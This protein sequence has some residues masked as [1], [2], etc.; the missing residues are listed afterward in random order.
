MKPARFCYHDPQST[1]DAMALLAQYGGEARIVAGGQSLVPLMNFRLACPGHLVGI[2]KITSLDYIRRKDQTLCIGALTRQRAVERSELV[3]LCNPLLVEASHYI[4]RPAIR[5]RGTVCGSLAHAD[6]AAEWPALAALLDATLVVSGPRGAGWAFLE[7][8]R[9]YGDFALV[10]VATWITADEKAICTGGDIAL[11]SVGPVPVRA[12]AAEQR[13]RGEPLTENLFRHVAAGVQEE[14]APDSDLHASA[15]YRR[16]LTGVL[17]C[18]NLA[19]AQK[20]MGKA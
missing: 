8:S 9:R 14:I 19:L 16:H 17:T 4:G 11:T 5:N 12:R 7:V 13:M 2:N 3:K 20:R 10:G 1:E 15:D 18:R 6:P